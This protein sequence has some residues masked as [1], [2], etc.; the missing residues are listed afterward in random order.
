MPRVKLVNGTDQ[1]R[2]PAALCA[3]RQSVVHPRQADTI[4][5]VCDHEAMVRL[6]RITVDGETFDVDK[7]DSSNHLSWISGP[8]AGYGFTIGRSDGAALTEDEAC[9]EVRMFLAAIDPATGYL[10]G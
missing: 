9:V 2:S 4:A 7:Q 3:F 10:A 8:N 6:F 1:P 5:V